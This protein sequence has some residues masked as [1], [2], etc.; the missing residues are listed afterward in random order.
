MHLSHIVYHSL[1]NLTQ[2]FIQ[3]SHSIKKELSKLFVII[4][5][6]LKVLFSYDY[7]I[8]SVQMVLHQMHAFVD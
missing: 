3:V 2:I 5:V 1:D 7:G 6:I 4:S 8:W